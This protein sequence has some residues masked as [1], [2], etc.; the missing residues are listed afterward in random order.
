LGLFLSNLRY[1]ALAQDSGEANRTPVMCFTA[2]RR[3][4]RPGPGSRSL[5]E[6]SSLSPMLGWMEGVRRVRRERKGG[7]WELRDEEE[8]EEEE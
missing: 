2:T 4:S 1:L 7:M 6:P 5:D 8:E 3:L